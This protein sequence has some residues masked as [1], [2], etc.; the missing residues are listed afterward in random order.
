ML[1]RISMLNVFGMSLIGIAVMVLSTDVAQ[2]FHHRRSGG[3]GCCE[4][5][6]GSQAVYAKVAAIPRIKT[7]NRV[8]PTMIKPV[9]KRIR[10]RE[11]IAGRIA[12]TTM[13]LQ[14]RL[15]RQ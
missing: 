14:R 13:S 8:H 6:C 9:R 2:A 4:S 7:R 15:M 5:N 1:Q 10:I 12:T 3:G 11:G